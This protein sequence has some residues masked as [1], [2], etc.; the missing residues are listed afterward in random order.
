[1]GTWL[2]FS[3]LMTKWT[4]IVITAAVALVLDLG[5]SGNDQVLT[6]RVATGF[7]S[8]IT[9]VRV[10]QNGSVVA[11]A[12]VAADG[13][14]KLA[15]APGHGLALQLVG[16]GKDQIVFPRHVGGVQTTFRVRS[17]GAPFDL[18]SIH[19]LSD[20]TTTP[21]VFHD[22]PSNATDCDDGVDASGATCVDDEDSDN[23]TCDADDDDAGE[24]ADEPDDVDD[25]L[26]DEGDAVA[27]HNFPADG[28]SDD[29]ADE[30]DDGTD[31]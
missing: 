31:D 11:T 18:G 4:L 26:A 13:S 29:D 20:A 28:C 15:V 16:T 8:A 23:G 22:G 14:F 25:G 10:V 21:F 17:G 6:G 7:P 30:A 1:V 24:D 9:T 19:Y 5:C 2:A 3:G 27:D 12:P